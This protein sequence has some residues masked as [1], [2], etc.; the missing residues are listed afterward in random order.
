MIFPD[1]QPVP[2]PVVPMNFKNNFLRQA[3]R[4]GA[5]LALRFKTTEPFRIGHVAVKYQTDLRDLFRRVKPI[6][7]GFAREQLQ[8]AGAVRLIAVS[9]HL[10]RYS[11]PFRQR[12]IVNRNARNILILL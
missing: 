4:K 11:A 2:P 1:R 9:E 12:R 5:V 3:V 8:G 6:T 7:A 10:V